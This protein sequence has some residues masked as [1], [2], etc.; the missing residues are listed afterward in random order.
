MKRSSLA[1]FLNV[2]EL[3]WE[4]KRITSNTPIED[5]P[6]IHNSGVLLRLVR[7]SD[8][9]RK[10]SDD[11]KSL[12]ISEFKRVDGL[13]EDVD[14]FIAEIEL[15]ISGNVNE[16]IL[17]L[18]PSPILNLG[19]SSWRK[20]QKILNDFEN[21]STDEVKYKRIFCLENEDHFKYTTMQSFLR[22]EPGAEF[23]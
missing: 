14:Q 7:F 13:R 20:L 3:F 4:L 19:R 22:D 16:T 9:L 6:G 8:L 15:R 2:Y 1:V 12:E 21:I 10:Q 5:I 17:D 11:A 23:F 18:S